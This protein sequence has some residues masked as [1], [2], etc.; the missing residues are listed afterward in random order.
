MGEMVVC[1]VLDLSHGVCAGYLTQAAHPLALG[2]GAGLPG[3]LPSKIIIKKMR[4]TF[5]LN[6]AEPPEE[7]TYLKYRD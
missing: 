5:V 2:L 3:G 4:G 7:K 1:R 6:E